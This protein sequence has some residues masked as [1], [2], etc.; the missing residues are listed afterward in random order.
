VFAIYLTW[1]LGDITEVA[2]TMVLIAV[3]M[4]IIA[5]IPFIAEYYVDDRRDESKAAATTADN[6]AESP[7]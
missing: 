3:V 2:V 7:D 1:T 6:G 4:A 5:A